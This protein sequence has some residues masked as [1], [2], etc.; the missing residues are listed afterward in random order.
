MRKVFILTIAMAVYAGMA[1]TQFK[2]EKGDFT[3]ELQFRPF[4][5]TLGGSGGTPINISPFSLDGLR[6]RYF[7]NEKFAIRANFKIDYALDKDADDIDEWLNYY[8]DYHRVGTTSFRQGKTAFGFA[9]G[10]EYH[11]G[12]FERLSI[13]AGL[14]L[15]F[16]MTNYKYREESDIT[17]SYTNFYSGD[18]YESRTQFDMVSNSSWP[19]LGYQNQV[20]LNE[21]NH[22]TFGANAFL[23][24]D[25]YIYKGL[26]IGAELGINYNHF[27]YR[28][29][30]VTGK[31]TVTTTEYGTTT[32]DVLDI[33]YKKEGKSSTDKVNLVCEPAIRLG[34]KF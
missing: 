2:P 34:W 4:S 20:S 11:F 28:K 32:E 23:G 7:F 29:A 6:F 8:P 5:F 15:F 12:K 10:F 30:K 24:L 17:I 19:Y 31:R 14:D 21:R 25:F 18:V 33:N 16:G 13:Y 9:P 26:Y 22:F 1:Q 27:A 3:T